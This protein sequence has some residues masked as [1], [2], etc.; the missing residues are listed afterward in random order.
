MGRVQGI[1]GLIFLVVTGRGAKTL[2]PEGKGD[3]GGGDGLIV[4]FITTT[5]LG[6]LSITLHKKTKDLT[7]VVCAC[8]S[9]ENRSVVIVP[10]MLARA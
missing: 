6:I 10:T 2:C 1:T 9:K 7:D 4:S 3:I 8:R 5:V